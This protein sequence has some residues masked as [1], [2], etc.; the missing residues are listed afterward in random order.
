MTDVAWYIFQSSASTEQ[1]SQQRHIPIQVL[2]RRSTALEGEVT[3][4]LAVWGAVFESSRSRRSLRPVS[5]E[6]PPASAATGHENGS[7]STAFI[8]SVQQATGVCQVFSFRQLNR[9]FIFSAATTCQQYAIVEVPSQISIATVDTVLDKT[10]AASTVL[11]PL[12]TP[13]VCIVL[14]LGPRSCLH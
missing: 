13:R 4:T 6:V 11:A 1:L 10:C 3:F 2:K 14:V 7:D 9:S 12:Y 8:L 5:I